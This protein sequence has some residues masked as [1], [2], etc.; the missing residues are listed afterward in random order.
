MSYKR[1]QNVG[2]NGELNFRT[3]HW[4]VIRQILDNNFGYNTMFTWFSRRGG[5]Y[6]CWR[7]AF[8]RYVIASTPHS[9]I[10]MWG[11]W[12]TSSKWLVRGLQRTSTLGRFTRPVSSSL[13]TANSEG[14]CGTTTKAYYISLNKQIN[15]KQEFITITW[16]MGITSELTFTVELSIDVRV[17]SNFK[18]IRIKLN[19]CPQDKL[20][21]S[22]H[23]IIVLTTFLTLCNFHHQNKV[24]LAHHIHYCVFLCLKQG[25]F[26][27]LF[28]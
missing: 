21:K 9:L 10:R 1:K 11:C 4:P 14:S 7:A 28:S 24:Q 19:F 27:R 25:P 3:S 16:L 20:I 12:Q 2:V 6:L 8:T 23:Q 5:W 13:A 17:N 26:H 15:Y 18:I 22:P